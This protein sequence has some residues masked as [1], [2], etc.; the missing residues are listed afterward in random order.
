MRLIKKITSGVEI[1]ASL[2]GT[3]VS[4]RSTSRSSR[5]KEAHVQSFGHSVKCA[6]GDSVMEITSK[7]NK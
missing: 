2:C 3:R 7:T 5:L 4:L 6:T 1:N